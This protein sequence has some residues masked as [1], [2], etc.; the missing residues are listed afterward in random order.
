MLDLSFEFIHLLIVGNL[1]LLLF[2]STLLLFLFF[3]VLL[4]AEEGLLCKTRDV[5]FNK[6]VLVKLAFFLDVS[7]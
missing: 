5:L 2:L 7:L 1:L 6:D 4:V 3:F